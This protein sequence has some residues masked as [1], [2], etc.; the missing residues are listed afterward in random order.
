[1]NSTLNVFQFI[2][3]T[4]LAS[5][6]ITGKVSENVFPISVLR[7]IRLPYIIYKPSFTGEESSKDGAYEKSVTVDIY[8]FTDN[9]DD[10]IG[11]LSD[12]E[13]VFIGNPGTE[14]FPVTDSETASWD[15][16]E[17]DKVYGGI[18]TINLTTY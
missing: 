1:M 13:K 9:M 15:F 12:V 10:A 16:S 4:L 8:V 6:R 11:L 14:Y 2:K 5:E 3:E 7:E 17:E 18:I